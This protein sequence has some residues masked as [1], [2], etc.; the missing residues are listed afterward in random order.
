MGIFFNENALNM[1][2]VQEAYFGKAKCKKIETAISN[3]RKPYIGHKFGGGINYYSDPNFIEVG[4]A[5]KDVFGFHVVDFNIDPDSAINAYT[6][7]IP[8]SFTGISTNAKMVNGMINYKDQSY[9]NMVVRCTSGLW[10]S[11]N[12]SDAEITA[13]L[14]HEIGHNF[15]SGI[16]TILKNYNMIVVFINFLSL[17]SGNIQLLIYDPNIKSSLSD[18]IKHNPLLSTFAGGIKSIFAILKY[19]LYICISCVDYFKL[20]SLLDIGINILRNPFGSAIQA[21][22][23]MYKKGDE[24]SSD[25]FAASCGYGA[26]LA[27]ALT[28]MELSKNP[29]GT[30]I[31][32]AING[33]PVLGHV[34]N[35][36]SIP[37]NI[38][39]S[40]FASHP[41]TPK[42]VNNIISELEKELK[43][44]KNLS[45]EMK[46][47][48]RRNIE[49]LKKVVAD[50]T[51]PK[52]DTLDFN[53]KWF[54]NM[55]AQGKKAGSF[56][57]N[58]ANHDIL[59]DFANE[60]VDLDI[61]KYYVDYARTI[62]ENAMTILES[63]EPI[64]EKNIDFSE[65]MFSWD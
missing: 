34:H 14:L 10:A 42:R 48:I 64:N 7:P 62:I 29:L 11:D 47:E 55:I 58:I 50:Y 45:P 36:M 8:S 56:T 19:V 31:E 63:I 2:S 41:I 54:A 18:I 28:K 17:C 30:N 32:K 5:I 20:S 27:S 3:A 15:S 22:F 6:Y 52:G 38:C 44:D 12:F 59:D 60:S 57:G 1:I 37:V 61:D 23:G 65:S 26:E 24:Y 40:P 13:I 43:K 35:F 16:S 49:D 46:K 9:A 33:I 21:M 39:L 4:K 51:A 53:R 25:E